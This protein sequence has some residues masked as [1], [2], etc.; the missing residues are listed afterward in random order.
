MIYFVAP[1][2][3]LFV[4]GFATLFALLASEGALKRSH[5]YTALTDLASGRSG[6]GKRRLF[7]AAVVILSVGACA[8]MCG[9]GLSDAQRAKACEETCTE[10]GYARAEIRGSTA[11][12]KPGV[13]EF[14]ACACS[15]GPAPDPLE[16]P[17]NDLAR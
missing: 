7:V 15:E 9:V 2:G 10:R 11:M 1:G 14:V 3:T 17:A 12:K 6:P 8:S 16:L 5:Q 4:I 13:H